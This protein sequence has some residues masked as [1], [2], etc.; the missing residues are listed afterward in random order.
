MIKRVETITGGVE[1]LVDVINDFISN[2]LKENDGDRLKPYKENRGL[3]FE[4]VV[5]AIMHIGELK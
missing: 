5:I 1:F 2:E 4:T 3:G